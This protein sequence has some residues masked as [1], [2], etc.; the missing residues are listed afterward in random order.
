MLDI[1]PPQPQDWELR[2][3]CWKLEGVSENLK[4]MDFGGMG[5]FV[6]KARLGGQ[7]DSAGAR[8]QSTS[9]RASPLLL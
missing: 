3:I 6:I 4:G 1:K 7:S 5:D 2:V 9:Q 8:P